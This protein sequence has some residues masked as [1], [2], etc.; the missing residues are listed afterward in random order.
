MSFAR[1]EALAALLLLPLLAGLLAWADRRRAEAVARLGEPALVARLMAG[2]SRRRRWTRAALRLA[3]L[4]LLILALARPQWGSAEEVV[5]AQG[6]QLVVALDVS[7]SMLAQDLRPSRLERAKLEVAELM[8]RLG[9]DEVA[10]VLFSGASFVQLP[11]TS[12]YATARG[13]LDAARPETISQPGTAVGEAV[14]TALRA[15]DERRPGDK[16]ILLLT[17]GEDHETEPLAAAEEAA[18][19]GVKIFAI[20]FGS[21]EGGP[22][23]V[24]DRRGELLGYRTDEAGQQV[25]TRLD[26]ETLRA[27]TERTGGAYWRSGAAG[28]GLDG[29]LAALDAL[30]QGSVESRLETLRVERFPWFLGLALVLL[31][32]AEWLPDR[33]RDERRAS[34]PGA[35]SLAGAG[36]IAPPTTR[37]DSASEEMPA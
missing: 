10:L 25:T 35:A 36:P 27:M 33:R 17:D 21:P 34:A 29:V 24:Y 2:A 11:L 23:P 22:V 8:S 15:F 28:G 13:F 4:A 32:A 5:Q 12:D 30:E 20:G 26:E 9:G 19:A 31:A 6:L 18:E 1:P 3:A 16:A 37:Q 14:R 7:N